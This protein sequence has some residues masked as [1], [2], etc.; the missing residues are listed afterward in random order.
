MLKKYNDD[1][2]DAEKYHTKLKRIADVN[3]YGSIEYVTAALARQGSLYDSLRTG[4]FNT[5]EPALKLF[6]A[7]EE[8]TL[9][10]LENSGNDDLVDK[11]AEFRDKR[12]QLWRQKRDQELTSADTIMIQRYVN[13]ITIAKKFNVRTGAVNKALQRLAFFHGR[14]H[15]RERCVSIRRAWTAS[16]TPT[17]CSKRRGRVSSSSP[18][19]PFSPGP[20]PVVIQ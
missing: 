16:P 3:T 8:K 15:G 10:Q 12:T 7:S 14:A 2:K 20:I 1:A 13:A 6:N 18:R 17:A 9:K 4:L 5:R 19:C 11:A